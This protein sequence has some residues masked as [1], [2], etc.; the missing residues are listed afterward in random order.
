MSAAPG[1]FTT[2]RSSSY[3]TR[4]SSAALT[5]CSSEASLG[6][7]STTVVPRSPAL[8]RTSPMARSMVAEIGAGVSKVGMVMAS[9]GVSF[10]RRVGQRTQPV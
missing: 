10:E 2:S 4:V 5:S 1:V 9:C 3:S 8:I 7:T 6:C